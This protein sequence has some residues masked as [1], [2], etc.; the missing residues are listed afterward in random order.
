M[1]GD[2]AVEILL[3]ASTPPLLTEEKKFKQTL[4]G[5]LQI[6]GDIVLKIS[7][8]GYSNLADLAYFGHKDFEYFCS[9]NIRQALNRGDANYSDMF[10][11]HLQGLVWRAS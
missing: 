11:K 5:P 6:P 4:L 2:V 7:L 3:P 9:A 1:A 10:I 8:Y